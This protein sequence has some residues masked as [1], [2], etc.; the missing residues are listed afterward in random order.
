M[1]YIPP[2]PSLK[3][4]TALNLVLGVVCCIGLVIPIRLTISV[5]GVVT[6]TTPTNQ[7]SAPSDSVVSHV[8]E[9][10]RVY[11][12]DQL[13]FRFSQPVAAEDV[14]GTRVEIDD[15][16]LRIARHR[17]DC[18]RSEALARQRLQDAEDLYALN[19]E[20]YRQE[21]ISKLNLYQYRQSRSS[22]AQDLEQVRSSCSQQID[23]LR[24]QLIN[25]QGVLRKLQASQAF[26][27]ELV[28]P[29]R[30]LIYELTVKP[31]QR[32]RSGDVLA[33]FAGSAPVMV[34]LLVPSLERPFVQ[35]GSR[36]DVTSPAYSFLPTQPKHSCLIAT[37]SPDLVVQAGQPD[38]SSQV[39]QPKYEARCQFDGPVVGGGTPFLVGMEV[40]AQ[41]TGTQL[42]L[43]QLLLKGYR[44]S[45]LAPTP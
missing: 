9:E 4:V 6:S 12:K 38:A 41:S 25:S 17:E 43:F 37:I 20:A 22:A 3:S 21:A 5:R 31:G 2:I 28:A 44:R 15:L 19:E 13:L 42:S 34:T 45:L 24:S 29:E 18:K 30:G 16:T 8:P 11:D 14:S 36:F 39:S 23:D 32:V 27:G 40:T 7:L 33:R 26:H 10:G 1:A 35:V